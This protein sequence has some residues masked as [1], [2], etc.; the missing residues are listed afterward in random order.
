MSFP[1]E[2]L[3]E[4]KNNMGSGIQQTTGQIQQLGTTTEQTQSKV[5]SS[6]MGMGMAFQFAALNAFN[7]ATSIIGLKRSYEDIDRAQQTVKND[8]L[9]LENAKGRLKVATINL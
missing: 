2:F 8:A 5:K 1:L 9:N 7:L 3:L 6:G 4:V